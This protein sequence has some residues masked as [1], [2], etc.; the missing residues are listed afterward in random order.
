MEVKNK[1]L[2]L[3]Q[4]KKNIEIKKAKEKEEEKKAFL[5]TAQKNAASVFA[6]Y[7]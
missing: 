2:R 3:N 7:L 1:K 5:L 4:R 6:K